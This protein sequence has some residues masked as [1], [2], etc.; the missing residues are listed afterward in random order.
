MPEREYFNERRKNRRAKFLTLLG[1]KC[2]RC[3]SKDDLQF[4]HKRP[5]K[6][7]FRIADR[8]DAPEDILL[9]E[10]MK[11]ILMCAPC[12][13][14]KT[15]EKGEHGQPKSRHGTL[16]RYKQYGCRCK[17]CKERMSEYNKER[18]ALA[19][20]MDSFIKVAVD[21]RSRT[22]D[23]NKIRNETLSL[24][25]TLSR[26]TNIEPYYKKIETPLIKLASL[27]KREDW[28]QAFDSLQ[29]VAKQVSS[30]YHYLIRKIAH[31]LVDM[32]KLSNASMKGNPLLKEYL[33]YASSIEMNMDIENLELPSKIDAIVQKGDQMSP[34]EFSILKDWVDSMPRI[35]ME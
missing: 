22:A 19:E 12:H 16:H 1:G 35:M 7:E 31:A 15:R 34:D 14:D 23:L 24:I 20:L 13:R 4:D 10:V 27:I 6:K 33:Q 17:K 5:K 11:C 18:K 2:E 30:E 3:G 25:L 9:K 8:I 21:R 32:K 29:V 28:G 26:L